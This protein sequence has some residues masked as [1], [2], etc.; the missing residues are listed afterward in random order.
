MQLSTVDAVVGVTD[1]RVTLSP[2][3]Y[4]FAVVAITG[5]SRTTVECIALFEVVRDGSP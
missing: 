5:T 3:R 2:G 4:A 1:G